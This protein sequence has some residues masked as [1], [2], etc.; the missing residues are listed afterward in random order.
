MLQDVHREAIQMVKVKRPLWNVYANQDT[1]E[2]HM[3]M[4]PVLHAH[5]RPTVLEKI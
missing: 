5:H 4:C 3:I 1:M 2:I